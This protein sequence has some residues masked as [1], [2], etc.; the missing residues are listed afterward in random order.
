MIL[1]IRT[2]RNSKQKK[3][4]VM[5]TEHI[6]GWPLIIMSFMLILFNLCR[7]ITVLSIETKELDLIL[8]ETESDFQGLTKESR[9][10]RSC[11]GLLAGVCVFLTPVVKSLF[12]TIV[13]L[14][15]LM[16]LTSRKRSD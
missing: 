14:V 13:G 12:V 3:G 10:L 6:F 8:E 5:D 15:I 1:K 7:I 16:K 11:F 9:L 4:G 2:V